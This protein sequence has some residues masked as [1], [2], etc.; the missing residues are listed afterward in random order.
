M[1]NITAKDYSLQPLSKLKVKDYFVKIDK[2]K[3]YIYINIFD[4]K[5][6]KN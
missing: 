6:K 4:N 3:S 1:A 5:K 2:I